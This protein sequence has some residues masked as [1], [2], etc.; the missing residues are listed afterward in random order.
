MDDLMGGQHAYVFW[1]IAAVRIETKGTHAERTLRTVL[2][3]CSLCIGRKW[4]CTYV[5]IGVNGKH[6][7]DMKLA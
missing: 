5:R 6:G 3:L 1:Y 7:M 2:A 4:A